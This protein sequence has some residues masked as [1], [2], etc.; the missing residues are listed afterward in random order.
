MGPAR[1]GGGERE[2][3]A[4]FVLCVGKGSGLGE[5]CRRRMAL[6]GRSEKLLRIGAWERD[7]QMWKSLG[8]EGAAGSEWGCQGE[9]ALLRDEDKK[10]IEYRLLLSFSSL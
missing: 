2:Q 7:W 5:G 10:Y 4:G 1:G 8:A 9:E 6:P 3:S